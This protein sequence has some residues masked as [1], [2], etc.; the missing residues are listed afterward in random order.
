MP[1]QPEPEAADAARVPYD[2]LDDG[3]PGGWI[4]PAGRRGHQQFFSADEIV[5]ANWLRSISRESTEVAA[6]AEDVRTC[7]L[8]ARCLVF[9]NAETVATVPTRIPALPAPRRPWQPSSDRPASRAASLAWA[10]AAS[11]GH[12]DEERIRR[13]V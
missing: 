12:A 13:A 5:G 7:D 9:S 2:Q 4:R 8:G 11:R 10:S 3:V 6:F 1:L